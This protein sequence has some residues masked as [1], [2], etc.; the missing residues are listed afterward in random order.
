MRDYTTTL[1]ARCRAG[2]EGREGLGAFLEKRKPWWQ[3]N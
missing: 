1:I 3:A 2:D